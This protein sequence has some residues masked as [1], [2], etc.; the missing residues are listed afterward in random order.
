[1]TMEEAKVFIDALNKLK[2]VKVVKKPEQLSMVR[3]AIIPSEVPTKALSGFKNFINLKKIKTKKVP[4][5][6]MDIAGIVRGDKVYAAIRRSGFYARKEI[7]TSPV[8]NIYKQ[9]MAPYHMALMQDGYR[10]GGKFG[11]IFRNVWLPTEEAIKNEKEFVALQAESIRNLA[12]KHKI[13]AT[14]RNL[15]HLSDV[16][17]GKVEA[18]PQEELF[19][20]SLR[21]HLDDLRKQANY[22]RDMM[23]KDQIGYIEDYVPHLQ[24]TSLWN[25]L[26]TNEATISDNLDFIIPNQVKN[27]FS[28]KR[29]MEEMP[30]A[31]RNLFTLLD[32]YVKAIAKDIYITP[33]IENI[34]AY[35]RVLKNRELIN[36]SK[37]WDEYIRTGLIGKQHKLDTALSIGFKG[38]KALQKWNHM[39][40]LAFL[41]GKAAWNVATQ[42]LSY[43]MNVPMETGIRNS[44]KGIFKS[45]LNRPLR[46]FVKENSKVLNIKG[47]DVHSIAVGE[48][49][50]IQ[51][52]IYRTKI[53]KYNHFISM[54]SAIE[55]RELT[56]ASY[57]AGLGKAKNLGY[58]GKDALTFADLTAARTQSMYNKENRALILNSDIARTLFPFQSFSV[59][60]FNHLKEIT[61]KAKGAESLNYRQRF[62]KLFGLLVGLYLASLYSKAL[63][64]RRKTTPGTFIPFAGNYV[65]AL[66]AKVQNKEYYGGR[67][68]ITVIQISEDI[69]RGAKDFIKYGSLRRLR[70]IGINFGLALGGIGGGG[71]INNI[72]DGVVADIEEDVKNVKGDV[73]FRVEDAESKVKAPIFGVW[74]TKEGIE[75]W[76]P[77]EEKQPTFKRP[78][79][80][81]VKVR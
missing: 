35:N 6:Q 20:K 69:I 34:K 24:K 23:G 60:M 8:R 71:Q 1:M 62:G 54:L 43:M 14:K 39:V 49:R 12:K 19:T 15:R 64:G 58:T 40:N 38:R 5:A 33:A 67:S 37:Y 21:L 72:I 42:P 10:R 36:A 66:T 32:R 4:F 56:L 30:K 18:T 3:R 65:D 73:M 46:K 76:Q 31:E 29:M 79:V 55:E 68:P 78:T 61:T 16:M 28:F 2:V 51:N 59:E 22:V 26:L 77:K 17:E 25:Q 53:D 47:S 44:I 13:K 27:P 63:T 11:A 74:A 75:Y 48:G 45:F 57:I 41:T 50:N 52:R 9:T 80:K 70:K 81:K 7:Q